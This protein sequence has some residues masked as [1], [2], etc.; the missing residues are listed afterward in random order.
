MIKI[1]DSTYEIAFSIIIIVNATLARAVAIIV[2][3]IAI[4]AIETDVLAITH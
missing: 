4:K 2:I 3:A 1:V